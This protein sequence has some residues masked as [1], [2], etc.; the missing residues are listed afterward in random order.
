MYECSLMSI[1]FFK[2]KLGEAGKHAVQILIICLLYLL[3]A[4]LNLYKIFVLVVFSILA[5]S[6]LQGVIMHVTLLTLAVPTVVR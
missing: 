4:E 3:F 5:I 6:C 1:F 2:I